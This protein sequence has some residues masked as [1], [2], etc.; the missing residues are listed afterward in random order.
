MEEQLPFHRRVLGVSGDVEMLVCG[1]QVPRFDRTPGFQQL[2]SQA[3]PAHPRLRQC[4]DCPARPVTLPVAFASVPA[5]PGPLSWWS[6][7]SLPERAHWLEDRA[8]GEDKA[9]LQG[10]T[11]RTALP[12]A[13]RDL[14]ARVL[15]LANLQAGQVGLTLQE[16][17]SCAIVPPPVLTGW[18]LTR[19]AA[20]RY[21]AGQRSTE[22]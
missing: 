2:V 18:A 3:R 10:R 19:A 15:N 13:A 22:P 21:E 14:L 12:E 8:P 20:R 5:Q 4:H 16:L 11:P 7:L 9:S 1:H 17:G 6:G